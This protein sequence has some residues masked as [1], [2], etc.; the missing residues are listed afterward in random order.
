MVG[1]G[2]RSGLIRALSVIGHDL[3]RVLGR[4]RAG[5]LLEDST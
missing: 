2:Q 4:I 5:F 1:R 3:A